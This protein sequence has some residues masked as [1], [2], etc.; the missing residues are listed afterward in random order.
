M[1]RTTLTIDDA[2][3]E[4]LKKK[5]Y[6]TGKSFKQVVNETLLNG[7]SNDKQ[8]SSAPYRLKTISMGKVSAG[9]DLDKALDLADAL[10]DMAIK[11][12]M[13]LRK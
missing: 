10:E 4:A 13:E 2:L 3:A 12:K 8:H 11:A 7:L 5:A 9:Y 1:M 6:E